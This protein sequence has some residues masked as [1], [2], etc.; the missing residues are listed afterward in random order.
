MDIHRDIQYYL[1]PFLLKL[2]SDR[3]L[4][5]EQFFSERRNRF[6]VFINANESDY[7]FPS[8]MT[9]QGAAEVPAETG[10]EG[11]Q[12]DEKPPEPQ[13]EDPDDPAVVERKA[14]QAAAETEKKALDRGLSTLELLFPKAGWDRLSTFPDIYPYF[15]DIFNMKKGYELVAPTDPMQQVAVLMR[16]VEEFCFGLRYIS[17]GVVNGADGE[18]VR[19]D[20]FLGNVIN[21]WQQYIDKSFMKEYLPRLKEYCHILENSAESRTSNYAK[22]ILNELH[23]VK[24]LFFLPFY[25]FES[26]FPPTIK[27]G[28]VTPIYPEIRLMRKYL[29]A[30]A[31][32]IEQGS[33]QGGAEK[34][35]PC[36]GIDNPWEPYNFEVPNPVSTRLDSIL[37]PKKRNNAAL[38]FFS[39]SVV[40]VL[41]HLVNDETS[42]AYDNRPG[43]LFR[44]MNG[45]GIM[46]L[47]GV[48]MKIDADLIF[49]QARKD[50]EKAAKKPPANESGAGG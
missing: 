43:P 46:P 21:H 16:I 25:K 42:W 44:S 4:S 29:T 30:V 24:R 8:A 13:E 34:Q 14:K 28:D 50:R 31:A 15:T 23:W 10:A 3:W 27:K 17:F 9:P 1:Y 18:P 20:D 49:R 40:V 41:D 2:L 36:D 48:E 26:V 7:I 38:I 22:R 5:Y 19:V 11:E 35:A 37:E 47:F 32:G 6:M 33:R 12:N 45:E 39:L